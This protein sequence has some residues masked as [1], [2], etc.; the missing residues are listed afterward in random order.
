VCC[1][2]LAAVFLAAGVTKVT[3]LGAFRDRL[4]LHSD[5]PLWL[6]RPAYLVP[7]LELVIGW[8]LAVGHGRREAAFLAVVLLIAF[9]L[10]NLFQKSPEDCG[11]LL[12]PESWR[13]AEQGR[14]PLLRNLVLLAGAGWV[15]R[16]PLER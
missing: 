16:A 9:T 11:C 2:L 12:L 14:W 13:F 15:I 7:W 5:L 3:D 4:E 6:A 10:I 8:C 1:Y